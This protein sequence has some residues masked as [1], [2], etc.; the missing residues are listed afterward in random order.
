MF[1]MFSRY[2]V[3]AHHSTSTTLY[4]SLCVCSVMSNSLRPHGLQLS[5]LPCHGIIPARILEWV[6]ISSSRGSSW[7][8]DQTRIACGS[9]IDWWLLYHWATWKDH[10]CL[11]PSLSCSIL[12]AGISCPPVPC[13]VSETFTYLLKG[14]NNIAVSHPCNFTLQC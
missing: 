7:P 5:G 8:R 2:P 13:T 12:R 6:A 1:F 4:M 3:C 10:K 11:Y 14:W 9:S